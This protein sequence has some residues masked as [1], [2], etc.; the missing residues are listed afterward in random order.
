MFVE[1]FHRVIKVIYL[2]H[3]QNR[4]V[5]VLLITL[6]KISRDKAFERFNKI[7]KGKRSHRVC[8]INKRHKAAEQ[9]YKDKQCRS[10]MVKNGWYNHSHN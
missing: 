5:D 7:E 1:A 6:L 8:E 4:R 9:L 10:V 3:K 2:H